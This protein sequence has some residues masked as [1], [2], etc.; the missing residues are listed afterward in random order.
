MY[1]VTGGAGFIG[2]NLLAALEERQDGALV[3]CDRLRRN[4]KWRNVGKRELSDV[5]HPQQMFDFLEANKK[6]ISILFH[7]GAVSTTTETNAD[8]IIANNFNLTLALFAWCT[9]NG[10]RIIYA[11][12]AATYGDGGQGFDDSL[13][14]AAL[15]LL[16][17][18]NA[19][20]WSKHLFDRRLARKVVEGKPLPP[21]WVGLKFFNVYGP[22]EYHKGSQQSVAAQIYPHAET[23]ASCSLFRSHRP[24]YADGEQKRDFVWVDDAVDVIMW[25]VDHPGISGLFNLGTGHART[26]NDLA[27]A[28]YRAAG[29][30][31][32]IKYID[33]PPAIRDKY[34]YLT[35]ARMD[36]LRAAGYAKPFTRLEDGVTTYVTR[37]LANPDR[38]R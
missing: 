24:D 16:Q 29:R 12:S 21:Q 30:E 11:S 23:G 2:S 38:Y 8:L 32:H 15:S 20:G 6:R 14:S 3:L 25:L 22:N 27:A 34:Q 33:M 35:E 19:Y 9:H 10:V 13:S 26:F 1:V 36:R 31:P 7:M 37:Y 28:V 4:D 17:P 5:V 18:L